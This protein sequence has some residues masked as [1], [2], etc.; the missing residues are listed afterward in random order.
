MRAAENVRSFPPGIHL[1][2]AARLLIRD[3][4]E[5]GVEQRGTF[6]ELTIVATATSTVDEVVASFER[7]MQ[8][9]ISRW[10]A[11]PEGIASAERQERRRQEAQTI[12]DNLVATLDD[13]DWKSDVAVINWLCAIQDATD[14]SGV[15]VARQRIIEAFTSRGYEPN[16][17]CGE[18]FR[19]DDR[20]NHFR[21]LVGQALD[22][23]RSV[24]IHPIVHKFAGE[25]KERFDFAYLGSAPGDR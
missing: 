5:S 13:I 4:L 6:N 24:A 9:E 17:N 25:W 2:E 18:A 3:A 23:L 11:S 21:W 20:D 1:N 10:R 15:N 8:E 19:A 14:H 7:D 16:A 12:H 22:G